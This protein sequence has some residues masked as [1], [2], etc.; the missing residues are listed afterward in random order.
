MAEPV[1]E[2]LYD[3]VI[4]R[5]VK[6]TARDGVRLSV[7]IYRP[8]R[9]GEPLPGP[10]PAVV[11]R[12]PYDTRSGKGPSGQ[13]RNGEFFAKRG[14][15]YVVQD[16]RGRYESEGDFVLLDQDGED[17]YD[18]IEWLAERPYCNGMI[19]TQG[20]S[21]RAWN[22]NATALLR[23]PH[24]RAMW[25][26]QGG[27]NGLTSAIRHNG[28]FEMR[29]FGWA[30]TNGI[31]AQEAHADPKVQS[32]MIH[33]A[34][35]MYDWLCR[36]PWSE[37]NSPL[38][39]LPAWETWALDL[40]RNA[41]DGPFWQNPSRNFEPY[42]DRS[43]DVPTVYA[44]SWYDSYARASVENFLAM[45]QRL[46]HQYLLMGAGV[47]GGP[48]FDRRLTG[49]VDM[50]SGAPIKGN[51][52]P[53]REIM[54][55]RFFDRFLKGDETAWVDQPKVRYFRM[56]GGEGGAVRNAAGQLLHGGRWVADSQ[57]PPAGVRA[58]DWFL[59]P[60]A[61]LAPVAPPASGPSTLTYD[62]A[63]PMPTISGN[64]SSMTQN[65]PPFP[66]MMRTGDPISLRQ[67]LVLQGASDQ[68]THEGMFAEP[69]YGDLADRP[70]TLVFV[71]APFEA[72]TEVTGTP[73]VE[74]YLSSDAPDT[75]VYV[76][77][78]D[79]YPQSED[80][81]D[82]YRLNLCDSLFRV[83][84][85]EGFDRPAMMTP[86]EVVRVRFPLYPVSNAFLPGHRLRVLIS[87]SSFPR[88]DPNPNT[89]EPIGRHTRT[90]VAVNAI[91]HDPDHPS[92][93]ILPVKA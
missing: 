18:V 39:P 5:S 77:L 76:M 14:Y 66:R 74:I 86:G 41:D 36:L 21:L 54:M 30:V 35:H 12:S 46:D 87:A 43:A 75:D 78:Q 45:D 31:H 73:E 3:V 52:A 68:V 24:L 42:R 47:H 91:H 63:H 71:T 69:P 57:W 23:P 4:S 33:N 15:L 79:I 92:R 53:D 37:G 65:L 72:E 44:G 26:N 8:A 88:F 64:V 25:V 85:R 70:D 32:A 17:G 19:G 28:A 62:P 56:G 58:Q 11:T 20:S 7:D 60:D 40:Y 90:Q 10:F 38:S 49:Q 6:L 2:P 9:D 27:S 89:G 81:P 67:S 93:L 22:Q 83:R 82:G 13:A 48:N 61:G 1:S 29:W 84:Y 55:L 80:W 34:E 16:A 59:Q 51:L 50:G